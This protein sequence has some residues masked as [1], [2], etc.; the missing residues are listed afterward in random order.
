[1]KILLIGG[2]GVLSSDIMRYS[3]N[4]GHEVYI[5]NRNISK[6]PVPEGVIRIFADIRNT[7]ETRKTIGNETFDV[8]VDFL[9]YTLEDI[10]RTNGVFFDLCKQY[11]FISSACVYRRAKEDGVISEDSPLGNNDWDYSLNKLACEK[12]LEQ[13]YSNT[14]HYYTIVRPY[15]TYDETRIPF[16][17]MP[18]YGWHWSLIARM[19]ADKPVLLWDDGEAKCTIT[20]TKDLAVAVVGLFGNSKAI[21][22]AFTVTSDNVC[23]W[24]EIITCI[25]TVKNLIPQTIHVPSLFI[26]KKLPEYRGML[27][28][29]RSLDAV[30][31]NSKIKA[32]VPEF[33]GQSDFLAGLKNTI[34]FYESNHYLNGIDYLWDGKIDRLIDQ[35]CKHTGQQHVMNKFVDYLSNGFLKNRMEYCLG[36]N[37]PSVVSDIYVKVK[38]KFKV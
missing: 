35:Y 7:V 26:A 17:L 23:T 2:T 32:A 25:A 12:F 4:C 13:K 29:D 6:R 30:F 1:M 9:S 19:L 5:L 37:F 18:N 10:E 15:I 34:D 24:N 3:L 22:Q 28:G 36:R 27:L 11:V 8:V 31:D 33:T 14:D 20:S 38:T 21:N 16:G